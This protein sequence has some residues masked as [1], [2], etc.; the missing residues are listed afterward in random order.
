[1]VSCICSSFLALLA[2]LFYCLGHNW[3]SLIFALSCVPFAFGENTKVYKCANKIW[4][5]GK[6]FVSWPWDALMEKIYSLLHT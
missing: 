1:M 6:A 5:N 2:A 3:I 4:E